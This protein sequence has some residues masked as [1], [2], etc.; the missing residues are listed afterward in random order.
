[1]ISS[2][3]LTSPE[4]GSDESF[5]VRDNGRGADDGGS[6]ER[7][8]PMSHDLVI[9][10]GLVADGFGGE[11]YPADVA[12][13]SD[14]ITDIGRDIGRARRELKA[15]GRLVVPGFIDIH[16]HLDAQLWWDPIGSS[17]CWHGVTSAVLG[18]CGVTFA[19]CKK[20]DRRYLA[21]VMESV[22]DV[23][24]DTIM[25]GVDWSWETYGDYL[26]S[27]DRLHKG[28]NVG[29]M[30]GHCALRWH[31]MGERS[32]SRVPARDE[33]IATMV[34]LAEEALTCGALGISTSRTLLHRAPGGHH[35]PGTYADHRELAALGAV[36]GRHHRGVFEAVPAFVG[37][38]DD[39][40]PELDMLIE[41]ARST[42]QSVTF[43]LIQE[44]VAPNRQRKIL[45]AV[46]AARADG[47]PIYPQTT[48]RGIGIWYGI[49]NETPFDRASAWRAIRN[50][51]FDERLEVLRDPQGRARLI[52]SAEHEP[53]RVPLGAVYVQPP[54]DPR[55]EFG[56]AHSLLAVAATRGVSPAEAFIDLTLETD[57]QQL[58]TWPFLNEDLTA[59]EE[60]LAS[61]LTVLGLADAGAHA[62]QIVDASQPTWFLAHWVRDLGLHS[63]GEGIRQ[64]TSV[65][66]RLFGLEDRGLL[67]EGSYADVVVLDV[68]ALGLPS[69][70]YV[71]DF[72]AGAGRFLQRA[73]GYAWTIVNGEVFMEDGLHTG[74]L[75]GHVLRSGVA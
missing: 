8:G 35:V 11:P 24:A 32:L 29:G 34:A 15:D 47:V 41:I 26:G 61:P 21:E 12:V 53:T 20:E 46:H 25:A 1:M 16:T 72:P 28:L 71:H 40:G 18:N 60:M 17:S 64:L 45:D 44:A 6:D 22:E 2:A 67:R 7:G 39:P 31:A 63:I 52:A 56:P 74:T 10:G 38:S 59:V 33:D 36:L 62:G 14:R 4:S 73:R 69:P 54:G 42:E 75:A 55:Y 57:G 5:W 19:P 3:A 65:P 66:A 49:V 27:L 51:S 43:T 30:V 50:L 23:P 70:E 48:V 68:D 13:D 9:R 37:G 58:F